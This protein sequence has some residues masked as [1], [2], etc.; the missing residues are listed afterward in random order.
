MSWIHPSLRSFFKITEEESKQMDEEQKRKTK[1]KIFS[2][3]LDL[4]VFTQVA[5]VFLTLKEFSILFGDIPNFPQP[6]QNNFLLF[7]RTWNFR[8]L[9]DLCIIFEPVE[10]D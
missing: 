5:S 9:N 2:K 4:D 3:F 8:R 1:E 6:P 10:E 7:G